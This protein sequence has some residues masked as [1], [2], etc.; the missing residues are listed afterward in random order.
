MSE[1]IAPAGGPQTAASPR[2]GRRKAAILVILV[3]LAGGIAGGLVTRAFGQAPWHPGAMMMGGPIDADR[4]DQN[5]DRMTRHFAIEVDATVE[6]QARLAIIAKAAAKDLLPL[7]D[8]A[9]HAR[10]EGLDLLAAPGVDRA[11]IERLR[12]RQIELADTASK[13]LAQAIAD[14][15][16]VLT[17]EQRKGLAERISQGPWS[18]W[19]RG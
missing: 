19:H 1:Q 12:T 3:A 4:L 15:A 18:R 10:K 14:A 8:E 2:R 13:R 9:Q 5:L 17:P 16:D 7:R 11:A 6:Q